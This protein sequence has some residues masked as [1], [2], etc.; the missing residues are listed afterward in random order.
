[1]SNI[2]CLNNDARGTYKKSV[3]FKFDL[4]YI[5]DICDLT[6]FRQL[7]KKKI[8]NKLAKAVTAQI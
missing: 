4:N 5:S 6:S 2:G 3:S 8:I 1:M 7:S